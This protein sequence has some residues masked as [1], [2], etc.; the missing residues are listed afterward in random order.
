M[1]TLRAGNELEEH[2]K[3]VA[4]R[5]NKKQSEIMRNALIEYL[6]DMEDYLDAVDALNEVNE[7]TEEIMSLDDVIKQL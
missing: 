5:A 7:G 1:L 2:L 3:S 4:Q 6:E